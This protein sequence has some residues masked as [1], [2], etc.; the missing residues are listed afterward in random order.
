[1]RIHSLGLGLVA[2]AFA[3]TSAW[4]GDPAFHYATDKDLEEV[5]KVEAVEWKASAQAG[6]LITAGNARL[7]AL[8]AG[9]NA[10]RKSGM[11]KLALEAGLAYARSSIFLAVDG[12]G[13]GTIEE[14]EVDRPASTTNKGYAAKGRYDRFLTTNNSLY[15][16]ALAASDQPAGKD[17]VGGG[18]LGYSRQLFKSE[19]HTLVA[20]AGYDFSYEDPVV[21][22]GAGIHSG[23]LF[24]GYSGK[25]S[26]DTGLDGSLETL[27]NVNAYD[28]AGGEIDA[29]EDTRLTTRVSLTTKMFDD[30]SFRFGF[31]SKYDHAPSARPPF[32]LPYAVGFVPLADELDSKVEA[33]LIVN[34]L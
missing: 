11:N 1:M 15:V 28:G 20:E 13:N 17:F 18:Q 29:L 3:S 6:L 10:S 25:L 23:R 9:V 5:A 34:L 26:D 32:S 21:G 16:A 2:T 12:N 4:A 33:S 14:S 7:T 8:S 31:E 22:D 24:A 30:V 27:L 19:V